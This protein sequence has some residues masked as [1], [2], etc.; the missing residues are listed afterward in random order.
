MIHLNNLIRSDFIECYLTLPCSPYKHGTSQGA[1]SLTKSANNSREEE[2]SPPL[3]IPCC[4]IP[5]LPLSTK[6]PDCM[7]RTRD[8]PAKRW[9]QWTGSRSL[10]LI[11]CEETDKQ[12]SSPTRPPAYPAFFQIYYQNWMARTPHRFWDRTQQISHPSQLEEKSEEESEKLWSPNRVKIV[13]ASLRQNSHP[14]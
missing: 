14:N 10:L 6:L 5:P 7:V 8:G 13:D 4:P 12:T 1:G 2:S 9:G 3:T 11:P